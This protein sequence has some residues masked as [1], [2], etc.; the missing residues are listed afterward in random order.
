MTPLPTATT[1]RRGGF[2]GAALAFSAKASSDVSPVGGGVAGDQRV[3]QRAATRSFPD[4][5]VG[6]KPRRFAVGMFG[7]LAREPAIS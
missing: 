3:C 7:Q 2:A 4:A 1:T 6:I 5:R